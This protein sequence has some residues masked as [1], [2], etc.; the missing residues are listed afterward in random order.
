MTWAAASTSTQLTV[1]AAVPMPQV[2]LQ[3]P[4]GPVSHC[5]AQRGGS[6]MGGA[7][8]GAMVA[9]RDGAGGVPTWGVV[10]GAAVVACGAMGAVPGQRSQVALQYP[11]MKPAEHLLKARCRAR[12]AAECCKVTVDHPSA[13]AWTSCDVMQR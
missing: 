9:G 4:Q 13:G 10:A 11:S 5:T 2:V 7:G 3:G 1:R 6:I 8:V 12:A